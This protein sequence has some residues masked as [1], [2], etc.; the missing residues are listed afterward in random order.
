MSIYS[1]GTTTSGDRGGSCLEIVAGT[2]R[3]KLLELCLTADSFS[4]SAVTPALS[5]STVVGVSA[6]STTVQAEN[7][8][9]PAGTVTLVN[10]WNVS[11]IWNTTAFRYYYNLGT[12]G[13]GICWT[14]ERGLVIGAS[15]SLVLW[16]RGNQGSV[17]FSASVMIDE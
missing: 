7:S 5:R 4:G 17:S 11:P 1:G 3:A 15:S 9:D 16:F 6:A 14:F 2:D 10:S 13:V 8:A 12:R